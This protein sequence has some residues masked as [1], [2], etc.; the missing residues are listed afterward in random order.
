MAN[1]A[2]QD[3]SNTYV[4]VLEDTFAARGLNATVEGA[5]F[6]NPALTQPSRLFMHVQ[7]FADWGIIS[8]EQRIVGHYNEDPFVYQVRKNL[9]E[10]LNDIEHAM[11]RGSAAT[12]ATDSARQLE[13]LLNISGNALATASS[14]TTF[15]E[16]VMVDLL[17]AFKDNSY[18]VVPRQAYVNSWLK[19]TISEFSTRVTRNIDAAARAQVL[20]IERHDSDFGALDVFYTEDQLNAA[21]S[22]VE[23]NSA[24]FIDP[25]YFSMGW[26]RRPT[27]ESLS[28]DGLRDRFQINGQM[29][30]LYKT[31]RALSRATQYVAYI[32]QT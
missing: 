1:L 15:T 21:S 10:L 20:I 27:I 2:S 29:T 30:L 22:T 28:R 8:D 26:M 18:D 13:G 5:A 14:G 12:G 23:G 32:G 31:E 7:S 11:H 9:N 17:Q 4:E 25:S 16:Q 19:R 6:T 3:V 24:V